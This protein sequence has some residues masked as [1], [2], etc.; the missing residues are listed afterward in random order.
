[1]IRV[2]GKPSEPIFRTDGRIPI[3]E[4]LNLPGLLRLVAD[5]ECTV[6]G[7]GRCRYKDAMLN[8]DGTVAW[9]NIIEG[10]A[11]A[12]RTV[13]PERITK[14]HTTIKMRSEA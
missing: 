2:T 13:I 11:G 6:R 1:M 14:V 8:A 4:P 7:L 12:W 9:V 10:R 3:I 5:R